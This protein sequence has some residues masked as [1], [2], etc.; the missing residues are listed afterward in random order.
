VA[1]RA[2][3]KIVPAAYPGLKGKTVAVM[4]WTDDAINIDWP[5]MSIDVAAGVQKKLKLAQQYDEPD[6]LKGTTFPT[7]P[8][9]IIKFQM[10][11]PEAAFMPV[12]EVAPKVDV[13]RLIYVEIVG[14]QTRSNLGVNTDLYRGQLTASYKVVEYEH[15]VAK[16]VFA[17]DNMTVKFPKISS[18]DGVS[19]LGDD[20]TYIGTVDSVT[21]LLAQ[22]FYKHEEEREVGE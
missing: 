18:E 16:L 10:D 8:Q 2:M 14:F 3:P 1:A 17:E 4:V 7:T 21:T 5:K 11:H 6:E 20:R 22:R 12:S 9:Q 15:G 13:Q 19:N